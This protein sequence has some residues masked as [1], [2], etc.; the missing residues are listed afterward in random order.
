MHLLHAVALYIERLEICDII[1]ASILHVLKS[2][3]NTREIGQRTSSKKSFRATPIKP[4][5]KTVETVGDSL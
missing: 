1:A 4:R 2:R 3:A 5:I